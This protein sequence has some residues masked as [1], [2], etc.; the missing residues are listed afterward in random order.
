MPSLDA[1]RVRDYMATQLMTFSP[2]TEVMSAVHQLVNSGH[3]GAPVVDAQGRLIGMLS[4]KDCLNIAMVAAQDTCVAGPVSQY[5]SRDVRT[6]GSDLSITQLATLFLNNSH[7]RRYPVVDEGK[8][9]GQISRTDV[10][11]AI[12]DCC[13]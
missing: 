9:V 6:V 4:E 3:S 12:S 10:L 8:L 1:V 7:F 5:M 11:R 2:D 13:A